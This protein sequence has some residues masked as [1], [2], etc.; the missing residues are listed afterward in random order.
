M[1]GYDI[2]TADL[3]NMTHH[4]DWEGHGYLGEREALR[5]A[6]QSGERRLEDKKLLDQADQM[7]LNEANRQGMT[8]AEL[9][10]WANAKL[11]R[12]YGD[13]WFGSNGQHAERYLP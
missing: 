4:D 1:T 5:S 7:L 2:T 3:D 13:C 12:W 6:I 9:F 11:G 10:T 8:M